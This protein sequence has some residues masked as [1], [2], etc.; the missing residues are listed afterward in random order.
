[1]QDFG[2]D[3][4][5]YITKVTTI[6]MGN[7]TC[8]A[9]GHEELFQ[10]HVLQVNA[11]PV[12]RIYPETQAQEPGVAA[13][14]RCHA[15][16]IPMPRIT[17]LKNGMDVSS[18]M[19]KQLSLLANGSE[20]YISSVRY[21]DTGAYTCIAKNEVGVDEDISSLFIEDSAR[22]THTMQSP[23]EGPTCQIGWGGGGQ[24]QTQVT[25]TEK[26]IQKLIFDFPWPLGL[27]E[28]SFPGECSEDEV[29]LGA[30]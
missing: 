29:L 16:G 2:E 15:E 28:R 22:K 7:Y 24:C 4:S 5:L 25:H 23:Q 27:S 14:L 8:H 11:P 1:M 13:S 17:W 18:Q 6:H 21:E 19:S 26:Q 10:T 3:D 30:R 20:L 9:S 12:I